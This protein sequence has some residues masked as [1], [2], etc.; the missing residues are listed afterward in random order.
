MGSEKAD[1]G[2][3]SGSIVDP[4]AMG[5]VHGSGGY[6]LQAT[7]AA[8]RLP[9]WLD[10][11]L[12]KLHYEGDEDIDLW[13]EGSRRELHQ[14]K[15]SEMAAKSVAELLKTHVERHP[16]RLSDRFVV[17]SPHFRDDISGLM[18]RVRRWREHLS[19][20]D[21]SP[22]NSSLNGRADLLRAFS[23]LGLDR[24]ASEFALEYL[25]ID[26]APLDGRDARLTSSLMR[27]QYRRIIAQFGNG[28]PPDSDAVLDWVWRGMRD[29]VSDTTETSALSRETLEQGLRDVC[30]VAAAQVHG[31]PTIHVWHDSLAEL[32][33]R[34][35]LAGLPSEFQ[36]VPLELVRLDQTHMSAGGVLL[37]P[38]AAIQ[39]LLAKDGALERGLDAHRD[40]AV[41]YWG[42]PHIPLAALVGTRLRTRTVLP[43]DKQHS[44]DARLGWSTDDTPLVLRR[45]DAA[46]PGARAVCVRLSVS[47]RVHE[48]HAR[49]VVPDAHDVHLLL[50]AP[51]RAPGRIRSWG[52]C[53]SIASQLASTASDILDAYGPSE[54]HVFASVSVSVALAIG[55][56]FGGTMFPPVWVYDF[57]GGRY[58][59]GA[60]IHSG[61]TRI[62]ESG[63]DA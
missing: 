58:T 50:E 61:A 22:P 19:A 30:R 16:D 9:D 47:Y 27:E 13:F 8:V 20:H 56:A 41:V 57:K 62:L 31:M 10:D 26:R 12:V 29:L 51:L 25:D 17:V 43:I 36:P 14:V 28:G 45:E 38:A 6:R 59:W 18:D 39:E 11:G 24:S 7:Y 1:E 54:I 40:A 37:D 32:E 15:R 34:P 63:A 44:G 23:S 2:R 60:E 48:H 33:A 52:Q 4:K 35:V 55:R 42:L 5:G 46:T 21:E 3:A 53:Q 49:T